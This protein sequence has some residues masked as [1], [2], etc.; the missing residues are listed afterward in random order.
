MVL[1]NFFLLFFRS[2]MDF[3]MVTDFMIHP[4]Y[5]VNKIFLLKKICFT[6][7]PAHR[8]THGISKMWSNISLSQRM[9]ELLT[10]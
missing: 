4:V 10:F 1:H 3:K 5:F 9:V 2:N 6:T 8:A 7:Q